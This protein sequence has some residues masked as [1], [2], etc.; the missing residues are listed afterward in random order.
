MFAVC[1]NLL[2]KILLKI[3]DDK[4]LKKNVLKYFCE[5]NNEYQIDMPI[6]K[7]KLLELKNILIK[8][9]ESIK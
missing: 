6:L 8:E 7:V 1:S 5:E 4:M 9:K 2:Y 3:N